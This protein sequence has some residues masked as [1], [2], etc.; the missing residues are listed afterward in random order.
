MCHC[1]WLYD[2]D[3]Q[4][5][6]IHYYSTECLTNNPVL[7]LEVIMDSSDVQDDEQRSI[8]IENNHCNQRW[9]WTKYI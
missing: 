4:K 6:F 9:D 5:D 3:V 2:W 1:K 7:G 8:A